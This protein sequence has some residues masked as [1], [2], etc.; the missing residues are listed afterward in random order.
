MFLT[1]QPVTEKTSVRRATDSA[2]VLGHS[3]CNNKGVLQLPRQTR[4]LCN[5]MTGRPHLTECFTLLPI[6]NPVEPGVVH[7]TLQDAFIEAS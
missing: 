1:F 3:L 6:V 5:I 4:F 2:S 7:S